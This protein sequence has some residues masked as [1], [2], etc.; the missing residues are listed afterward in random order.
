MLLGL[1]HTGLPLSTA[2]YDGTSRSRLPL[3]TMMYTTSQCNLRDLIAAR[4]GCD[5]SD[6]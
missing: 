6:L 1:C 5:V 3:Y 2:Y 4:S